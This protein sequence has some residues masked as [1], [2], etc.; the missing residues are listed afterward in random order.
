MAVTLNRRAF[1]RAGQYQHYDIENAT[2][3]LD[4][5]LDGRKVASTVKRSRPISPSK[6]ARGGVM[7]RS[8]LQRLTTQ[9]TRLNSTLKRRHVIS[10]K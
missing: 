10:G 1:D 2:A 4:G 6:T 5:M 9:K 7:T 8:L 3:H